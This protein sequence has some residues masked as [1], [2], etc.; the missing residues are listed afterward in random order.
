M[1]AH[2][3]DLVQGQFSHAVLE[4]MSRHQPL[5]TAEHQV[6]SELG[7]LGYIAQQNITPALSEPAV[8][9]STDVLI[10]SG[11][12]LSVKNE[13]DELRVRCNQQD[14]LTT[15]IDYFI[16]CKHPRN[17]RPVLLLFRS[18]PR[19]SAVLFLH[20]ICFVWLGTRLCAGGDSAGDGLLIAPEQQREMFLRHAIDEL[21]NVQKRFH[22]LRLCV[23][24][25]GGG[26]LVAS[27]APGLESKFAERTVKHRLALADTYN[28]MLASFGPRT[29]RSLR[30]KRR[31]LE[32]TLRPDFFPSVE[33]EQALDVMSYLSSRSSSPFKSKWYLYARQKFLHSRTNAFAMAL[34]SHDGTW[35][36]FL[37]GWRRNGTTYVDMQMNHSAF[38]RE[39]LSAV[40]RA[41]LL[42]H[43]IGAGQKH[44]EFVGGCSVLLER[45]CSPGEQV[46]DLL[47][48]RFTIDGWC[49]KQAIEL[50]CDRG[51]KQWLYH[52]T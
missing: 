43:E 11:P 27:E 15:D 13:V 3:G 12:I 42:E 41:F 50:F 8:Q 14:D 47:V 6:Y 20:E 29:R 7:R 16:S 28:D 36:S 40:M 46:V 9:F 45:Y 18:G 48:N 23:K 44:L 52:P 37:S 49:L 10:G 24:T 33:P 32:D 26:R 21:V 30:T 22:T 4:G 25:C 38:K 2:S 35:L 17:C 51:F 39:S 19:L 34:R 31:Q 1:Q 5:F